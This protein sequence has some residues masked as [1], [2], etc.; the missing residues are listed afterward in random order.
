MSILK[1]VTNLS[2]LTKLM[3]SVALRRLQPRIMSTGN[4]SDFQSAY[5]PGHSTETASV[6]VINDVIT[7]AREQR[8]TFLL[9][10]DISAAFDTIDLS[11]LLGHFVLDFGITG[12]ALNWLRSFA[13]Y[14]IQYVGVGTARS[15]TV[16]CTSGVPQG[17][18]L[19]LYVSLSITL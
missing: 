15:T 10:L 9:S 6:K 14:R 12:R 11:I 1:P 13:T 17:S 3:E 5:I 16:N 7:A 19:A 18:V 4:F 2:T 8:V